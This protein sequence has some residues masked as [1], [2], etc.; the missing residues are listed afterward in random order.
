MKYK[1]I[2]LDKYEQ[3]IE[4]S[5]DVRNLKS[6]KN[7]EAK[8]KKYQ[9]IAENTIKKREAMKAVSRIQKLAKKNG[10]SEMSM[11]EINEEIKKVRKKQK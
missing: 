11:D 10:L 3:S 9:K 7:L 6:V 1:K 4:D 8:K 5:L 2:K